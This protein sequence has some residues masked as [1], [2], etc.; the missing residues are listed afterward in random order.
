MPVTTGQPNDQPQR[1]ENAPDARTEHQAPD[2]THPKPQSPERRGERGRRP[3]LA[4]RPG[5]SVPGSTVCLVAGFWAGPLECAGGVPGFATVSVAD[6]SPVRVCPGS[7]FRI[8]P[9]DHVPDQGK[10]GP[11]AI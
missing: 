8:L 2:P 9:S 11:G 1:A 6:F 4:P 5:H 7:L 10:R 3:V